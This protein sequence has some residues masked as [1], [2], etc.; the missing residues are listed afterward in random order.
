MSEN[1]NPGGAFAVL[2]LLTFIGL[3]AAAIRYQPDES[4]PPLFPVEVRP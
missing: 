4:N 2:L 3:A 1:P